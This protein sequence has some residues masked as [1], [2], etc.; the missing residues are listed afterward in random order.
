METSGP[1]SCLE[2][3]DEK[4]KNHLH[5]KCSTGAYAP[6]LVFITLSL[7]KLAFTLTL[8]ITKLHKNKTDLQIEHMG[9]GIE[10]NS[11]IK[12]VI[13]SSI[14]RGTVAIPFT[15][16]LAVNQDPRLSLLNPM[17]M[18][19]MGKSSRMGLLKEKLVKCSP[20]SALAMSNPNNNLK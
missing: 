2:R 20:R 10:H 14:F 7:S 4:S 3:L 6:H 16:T 11:G 5:L 15:T 18:G 17:S 8:L 9:E 13:F 19:L 1:N 12:L